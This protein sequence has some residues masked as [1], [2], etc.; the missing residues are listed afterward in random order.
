MDQRKVAQREKEGTSVTVRD[1]GCEGHKE[2]WTEVLGSIP[3]EGQRGL[4]ISPIL[5]R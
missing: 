2:R 4:G 3:Q 5:S 1:V